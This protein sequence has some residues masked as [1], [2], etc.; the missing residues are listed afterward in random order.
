MTHI[1]AIVNCLYK[2][3]NTLFED[4]NYAY[5]LF[6]MK[7]VLSMVQKHVVDMEEVT[8]ISILKFTVAIQRR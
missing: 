8:T 2:D 4:L 3:I 1:L 7:Q 6:Y 5:D